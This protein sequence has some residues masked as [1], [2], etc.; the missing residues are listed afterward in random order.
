VIAGVTTST[1]TSQVLTSRSPALPRA[2]ITTL[3]ETSSWNV[4]STVQLV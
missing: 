1:T 4:H 2:M 3:I